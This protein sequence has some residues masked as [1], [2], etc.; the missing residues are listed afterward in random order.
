MAIKPKSGAHGVVVAVA[1]PKKATP[2]GRQGQP[3][4]PVSTLACALVC[5]SESDAQLLDLPVADSCDRTTALACRAGLLGRLGAGVTPV[6]DCG[7][8][9][10]LAEPGAGREYL[11]EAVGAQCLAELGRQLGLGRP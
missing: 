9:L 8:C 3:G 11:V 7:H 6:L 4:I 5:G 10:L 1:A 2:M